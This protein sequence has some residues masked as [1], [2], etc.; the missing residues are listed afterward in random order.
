MA[1]LIVIGFLVVVVPVFAW[2]E[3]RQNKRKNSLQSER[4]RGMQ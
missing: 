1:E 3:H 4:V 2:A